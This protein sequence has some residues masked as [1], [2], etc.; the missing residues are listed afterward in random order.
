MK[1]YIISKQCYLLTIFS[2]E[3]IILLE[4]A[5]YF[6]DIL[7]TTALTEGQNHYAPL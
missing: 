4:Y 5:Q 7:E 2:E 1:L 3:L 6:M